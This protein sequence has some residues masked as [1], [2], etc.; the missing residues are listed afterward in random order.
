MDLPSIK[1]AM[2]IIAIVKLNLSR[3]MIIIR[4]VIE[5]MIIIGWW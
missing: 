3:R 5:R 1:L 4:M 2:T